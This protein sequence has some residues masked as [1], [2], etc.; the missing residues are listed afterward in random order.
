[1]KMKRCGG[2]MTTDEGCASGWVLSHTSRQQ[3]QIADSTQQNRAEMIECST[4]PVFEAE[5]LEG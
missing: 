4:S 3:P 1:M 2:G 5:S